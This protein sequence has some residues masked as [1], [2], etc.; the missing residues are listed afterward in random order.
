MKSALGIPVR[1]PP[2]VLIGGPAREF[3]GIPVKACGNDETETASLNTASSMELFGW[4]FVAVWIWSV[5]VSS[6]LLHVSDF[7]FVLI[8]LLGSQK[9]FWR[10][11]IE[12]SCYFDDAGNV[13]DQHRDFVLEPMIDSPLHMHVS[14]FGSDF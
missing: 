2:K 13:F 1:H 6:L 12:V 7:G 9:R 4:T 10:N 3:A 8:Y 11:G 14:I 5:A